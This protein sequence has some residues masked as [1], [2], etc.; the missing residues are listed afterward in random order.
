MT[1]TPVE[2]RRFFRHPVSVPIQ[3]RTV[4]EKSSDKSSSV[5]VSEGGMCFV[6]ER[7]LPVGTRLSLRIP[8]GDQVFKVNG[9]VAYCSSSRDA[10][11]FRTGVAFLDAENAFR[12]KLAEEILQINEHQRRISRELGRVV[13][14]EDAARDWIQKHAKNFSHLF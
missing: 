12:A 7:F 3:Y 9:Q 5:D 11:Q 14:E 6:A 2:K 4:T 10:G 13:T 8:V 1:Q